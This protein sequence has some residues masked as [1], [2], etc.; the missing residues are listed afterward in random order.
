[1]KFTPNRALAII[2]YLFG[3]QPGFPVQ[4]LTWLRYT[5]PSCGL[6][7]A[8]PSAFGYI[9]CNLAQIR[10]LLSCISNNCVLYKGLT[11]C[12]F[13][14]PDRS[15]ELECSDE[16]NVRSLNFQITRILLSKIIH[17]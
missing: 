17:R 5:T 8:I 6:Y 10:K 13:L 3:R 7:P 4:V 9:E 15:P 11:H 14:S 12:E 1:M 16:I 2:V